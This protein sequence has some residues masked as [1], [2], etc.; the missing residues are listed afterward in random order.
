MHTQDHHV[1]FQFA[2]WR[3]FKIF[4]YTVKSNKNKIRSFK[5]LCHSPQ[6]M[7]SVLDV[8]KPLVQDQI[9]DIDVHLK[10][11]EENLKWNSEG[12][13]SLKYKFMPPHS[14]KKVL[15]LKANIYFRPYLLFSQLIEIDMSWRVGTNQYNIQ[16]FRHTHYLVCL[17]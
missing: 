5:S 11:A 13:H 14:K 8:E 12:Q 9:R 2:H 6:V 10:K 17:S 3:F 4:L 7:D 15:L 1:P 16:T